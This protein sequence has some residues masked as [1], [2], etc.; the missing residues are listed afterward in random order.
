MLEAQVMKMGQRLP[1][2]VRDN[3]AKKQKWERWHYPE[4][5]YWME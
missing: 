4:T 1:S 2:G 5:G 3:T